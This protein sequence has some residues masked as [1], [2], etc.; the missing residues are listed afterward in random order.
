MNKAKTPLGELKIEKKK[1]TDYP[2][3]YVL[4]DGVIVSVI[5]YNATK[6]NI[7]ACMYSP[8][9]QEPFAVIEL[10]SLERYKKRK[11]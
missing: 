11:F 2:G 4:L 10:D 5:E 9:Q 1:D 6:K 3:F 8:I 7:E